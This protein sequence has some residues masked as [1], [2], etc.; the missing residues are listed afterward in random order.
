M[1]IMLH[2]ARG[3]NSF[4]WPL[5]LNQSSA[6][7]GEAVEIHQSMHPFQL[8]WRTCIADKR[9]RDGTASTY[10]IGNFR[11]PIGSV[12]SCPSRSVI[13]AL[14]RELA[15]AEGPET[16][17]NEA[18]KHLQRLEN[19]QKRIVAALAKAESQKDPSKKKQK[20]TIKKMQRALVQANEGIAGARS[21]V[22]AIS[23]AEPTWRQRLE[24]L[25]VFCGVSGQEA[26]GGAAQLDGLTVLPDIEGSNALPIL[27]LLAFLRPR[28][29]GGGGR[30]GCSALCD[31]DSLQVRAVS[32]YKN[33]QGNQWVLPVSSRRRLT[34]RDLQR[35]NEL[36]VAISGALDFDAEVEGAPS[37]AKK[38]IIQECLDIRR[39]LGELLLDLGRDPI[40]FEEHEKADGVPQ[41]ADMPL[42]EMHDVFLGR[43]VKR[44]ASREFGDVW[45]SLDEVGAPE[46]EP[47]SADDVS[48]DEK[49][50]DADG[51]AD[52]SKPAS[53]FS[54]ETSVEDQVQGQVKQKEKEKR[55]KEDKEKEKAKELEKEPCPPEK[56]V[57]LPELTLP[58]LLQER[59]DKYRHSQVE[60]KEMDANT[61][62]ELKAAKKSKK[63]ASKAS[64][65]MRKLSM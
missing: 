58:G 28:A 21:K 42:S 14:R 23:K 5:E 12:V 52:D 15:P 26:R 7:L 51:N 6:K 34:L 4:S 64:D 40:P 17:Q 44:K 33:S 62:S 59:A 32:L 57:L 20:E 63:I 1:R 56:L 22:D 8:Q 16:N 37:S 53:F 46:H 60:S 55:E 29:C 39:K 31:L 65:Q 35:T 24:R 27:L 9:K 19:L 45:I 38:P 10:G 3:K 50:E 43:G 47:E 30:G 25:A 2:L 11:N 41:E 49:E 48:K 36:R 13:K 61:R 54:F 18:V